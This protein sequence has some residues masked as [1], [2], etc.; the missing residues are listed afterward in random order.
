M[1]CSVST[2]HFAKPEILTS[3]Q[4]KEYNQFSFRKSISYVLNTVSEKELKQN[5]YKTASIW[6][7]GDISGI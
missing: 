2:V 7:A 6:S 3:R 1:N 4:L 5:N